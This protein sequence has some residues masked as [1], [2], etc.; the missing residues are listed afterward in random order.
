MAGKKFLD[1]T[2][3]LALSTPLL[4]PINI[5]G[6]KTFLKLAAV[7]S[8]VCQTLPFY[9]FPKFLFSHRQTVESII[10]L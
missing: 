4:L 8:A 3:L 1:L 10:L 9:V 7:L 6:Q 5:L 2:V